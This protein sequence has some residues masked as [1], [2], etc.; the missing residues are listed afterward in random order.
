MI[1]VA[2]RSLR[3]EHVS[4]AIKAQNCPLTVAEIGFHGIL[5]TCHC[6]FG[7]DLVGLKAV[8]VRECDRVGDAVCDRYS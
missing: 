7:E 3:A 2:M 8:F 5:R 1:T 4:F 6:N